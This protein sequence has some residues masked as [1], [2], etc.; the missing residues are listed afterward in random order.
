MA[1]SFSKA[2][3]GLA[4]AFWGGRRAGPWLPLSLAGPRAWIARQLAQEAR[5]RRFFLWLPVC[6]LCGVLAYFAAAR[7][8]GLAAPAIGLVLTG[9]L[10]LWAHWRGATIVAGLTACLACTFAG[11]GA[12]AWRTASV[13]APVLPAMKVT[14]VTAWIETVDERANGSGRLLLRV[15]EMDGMAAHQR[16]QKLR[17][18]LRTLEGVTVVPQAAIIMRASG[19]F[20][21]WVS[22][23]KA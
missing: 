14:K 12:G 10:A 18:T 7:E 8:P 20:A 5:E 9:A 11:F 2:G 16:P 22:K 23:L 13:A 19:P 21:F 6:F 4:G 1:G 15:M 17:V 3:A